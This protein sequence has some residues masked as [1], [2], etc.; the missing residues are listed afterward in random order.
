[1]HVRA[2]ETKCHFVSPPPCG[3]HTSRLPHNQEILRILISRMASSSSPRQNV[4]FHEEGRADEIDTDIV[5]DEIE[6][7]P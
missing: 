7:R 2:L 6:L 5:I 4:W 1:M 3:F